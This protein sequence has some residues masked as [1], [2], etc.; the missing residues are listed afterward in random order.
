MA[1]PVVLPDQARGDEAGGVAAYVRR[2]GIDTATFTAA[3][4]PQ[5][6]PATV[7]TEIARPCRDTGNQDEPGI[8]ELTCHGL[9]ALA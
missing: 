8:Y 9:H 4:E 1:E 6:T 2:A 3:L 5:L 7:G